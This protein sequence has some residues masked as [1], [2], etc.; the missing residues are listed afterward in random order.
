VRLSRLRH[1]LGAAAELGRRGHLRDPARARRLPAQGARVPLRAGGALPDRGHAPRVSGPQHLS[2]RS[3][4]VKNPLERLLDKEYAAKIRA[5]IDPA[6]AGVAREIKP[7][8]A[9]HEGTST[10]HYSIVDKDGNAVAVTY[11]LNE[12]F[13]AKVTVATTGI[14]LNNEMDD[15]TAKPGV[16]NFYGLVQ[17]EANAIAPG[18]RP[19]SSMAPTIVTRDGKPVLVMVAGGSRIIT[20][21]VH[22]ISTRSTTA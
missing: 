1:R 21:V 4:F 11:T 9:P 7:G 20:V 8:V 2:R 3:G 15:F 16:P 6:K 22:L 19:L 17:G 5:A 13:G 10:T 18:K 12:W 14:L